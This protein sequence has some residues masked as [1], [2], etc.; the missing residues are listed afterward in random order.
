MIFSAHYRFGPSQGDKWTGYIE[1]SGLSHLKELVS[2]DTMLCP[3]V[4]DELIDVDWQY[5]VH[6]DFKTWF[7]HDF[8]YLKKRIA[9]DRDRHNLLLITQRPA[10]EPDEI[11]DFEF[12]GYDILDSY[13]S[14]SVLTNCGGFPEIFNAS[15]INHFGLISDLARANEITDAIRKSEP[16]DP[17][18]HDCRMWA[19]ARYSGT[20]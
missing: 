18:C 19:Y 20:E 4:L 1:W 13:D 3:V 15:D 14:I 8:E 6:E 11:K 10:A 5:N 12:C 7:F 2:T 17:H 9:Y 16:D